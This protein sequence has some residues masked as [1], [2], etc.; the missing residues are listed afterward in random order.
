MRKGEERLGLIGR[1]EDVRVIFDSST[2]DESI[3]LLNHQATVEET[4]ARWSFFSLFLSKVM[5]EKGRP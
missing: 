2:L 1:I 4:A 3:E 5:P